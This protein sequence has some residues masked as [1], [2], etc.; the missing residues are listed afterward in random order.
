MKKLF[1]AITCLSVNWMLLTAAGRII[2]SGAKDNDLYLTLNH[3]GI[4]AKAVASPLDAVSEAQKG[5]A[6]IITAGNYP[7]ART[8]LTK[9][10]FTL[11]A[12]KK[13][14][15]Y[16]E[17]PDC[18]PGMEISPGTMKG[19][20]ERGVVT[21]S[22]FGRQL[23]E[24]SLLGLNGVHLIP[25]KTPLKAVKPLLV[26]A[27][28]AGFDSAIYGLT[29]TEVYP[30]LF[31][32]GNTLVATTCLT[33]FKTAR[34]AP[35]GSWT[36]VWTKI[37]EW[38]TGAKNT[39]LQWQ[40][41]PCPMYSR[42]AAMP[43]SAVTDAVRQ[44]ADWLFNGRFLVHPSWVRTV[45][46][47]QPLD[48]FNT[49]KVSAD[50]LPGD[51]SQ[52]VLEGHMSAINGDGSQQ[53]RYSLRA[54][55]HGE[56]AMLMAAA[57]DLTG[58]DRYSSVAEKL[59]DYVFYTSVFRQGA[60]GDR[61]SAS[62][63]LLSWGHGIPSRYIFYADDNARAVLGMIG[64]SALMKN[65]R[66]NRFL[67]ENIMANF[68]TTGKQGFRGGCCNGQ[69][70]RLEEDELERN[71]WQYYRDRDT[72]NPHPHFE[73]WMWACY[74]WLY[75]RTGYAPLLEKS[76]TAMQI[77]MEAYPDGW[78][79]T[80]GIQQERARM[81]LPLAWLVRVED[82]PQHRKW[83]DLIV[84]E[85]LRNQQ[86]SGA[87]RE[88]LGNSAGGMFGNTRS[89]A[90]YGREEAP[91]IARNGDP[92]SDMLYT[93]NFA[94]FALNEA[95]QATGNPQYRE[96]VKKLAGFL[97]RIQVKS[98]QP[99]LNGAWFRAFDYNRWDY[100]ASNA[101][102]GWGAWSTLTGWIQS[103]ITATLALTEKQTG[104][105]DITREMNMR[106]DLNESLWML[107]SK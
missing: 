64:A 98:S 82:T 20:W 62:Y 78:K 4:A 80:N 55:V 76:K 74:L 93:T 66:W 43:L 65:R 107:E 31:R 59:M 106:D 23:P 60:R 37:I 57:G 96:A 69:I 83:L 99:D 24:M 30:L 104:F 86:P 11:A 56:T 44:S 67:V 29:D 42:D 28:V 6:V 13:I 103:W 85:V 10:F 97:L 22:F 19:Q 92:V 14:R 72:V 33:N 16:V 48:A 101:D 88:E 36:T 84:Q 2:L 27:K 9:D 38:L 32:Q 105:W 61:D 18:L 25:V 95:A 100:W 53:Y 71:G 70:G 58:D 81:I 15:L 17:Y 94:F 75:G 68:R 102:A 26:F 8:P 52:G 40:S 21:S 47:Y 34:Y 49:P 50:K 73:S 39:A 77:T 35:V 1:L 51:G 79:W 3:S 90:G 45:M 63:G 54:D 87:I 5:D 89:N 46:D 91:L 7:V 12:G 41:D